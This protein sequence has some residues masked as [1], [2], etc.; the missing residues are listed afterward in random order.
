MMLSQM[1]KERMYKASPLDRTKK[2]TTEKSVVL[3]CILMEL[4]PRREH[5]KRIEVSL[6]KDKIISI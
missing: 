1:S 5:C 2:K 4:E 6:P 3:N